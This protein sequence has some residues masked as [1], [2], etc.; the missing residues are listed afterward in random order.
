MERITY[1]ASQKE[2][3][4]IVSGWK[5][6]ESYGSYNEMPRPFREITEAE[7]I[8]YLRSESIQYMDYKQVTDLIDGRFMTIRIFWLYNRGIGVV[9]DRET[10]RYYQMGCHHKYRELSMSESRERG[11]SHFGNCYHVLECTKCLHIQ[12]IDSSG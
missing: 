3:D 12:S 8:R 11:V 6:L 1:I 7:Y 4:E 9:F 5:W 2:R 10:I